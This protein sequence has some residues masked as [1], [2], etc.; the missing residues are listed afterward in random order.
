MFVDKV[1]ITVK[2]G[3]GGHG[4]CSF[5]REKFVP[6]GGPD[7]GDG[8]GGGH[9]ILRATTSQQ[10]LQDLMYNRHY[11]APNGPNGKGK[12]MH[13]RKAPDVELAVPVGTLVYDRNTRELL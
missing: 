1:T 4:C 13:G 10:S 12:D 11:A 8:G 9:V 6:R 5:R 3:D 7:G 2:A